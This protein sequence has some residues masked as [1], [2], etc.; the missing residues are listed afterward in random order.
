MH[1]DGPGWV[2]SGYGQV[3]ALRVVHGYMGRRAVDICGPHSTIDFANIPLA[4]SLLARQD[5]TEI[6]QLPSTAKRWSRAHIRSRAHPQT[7]SFRMLS[8]YSSHAASSPSKKLYLSAFL[9]SQSVHCSLQHSNAVIPVLSAATAIGVRGATVR[10]VL[11]MPLISTAT[12][13][14]E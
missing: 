2:S 8:T 1:F 3:W 12:R 6:W 9:A 11:I 13:Q 7:A 14:V 4:K 10:S 5:P